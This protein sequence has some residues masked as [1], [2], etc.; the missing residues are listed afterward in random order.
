MEKGRRPRPFLL[1]MINEAKAELD[2]IEAYVRDRAAIT[3]KAAAALAADDKR[4]D[5]D[6]IYNLLKGHA[7]EARFIYERILEVRNADV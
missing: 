4:D 3:Q 6:P 2:I 7:D 1:S 5:K